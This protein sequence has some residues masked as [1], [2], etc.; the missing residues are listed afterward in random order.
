MYTAWISRLLKLV[1]YNCG[2]E[3][4][5]HFDEV[6]DIYLSG[7][8]RIGSRVNRVFDWLQSK[9]FFRGALKLLHFCGLQLIEVLVRDDLVE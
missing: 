9:Q 3:G 8:Y 1:G 2:V 6:G 7:I 5:V 4:R